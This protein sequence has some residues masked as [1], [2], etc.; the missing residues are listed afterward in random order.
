MVDLLILVEVLDI[1]CGDVPSPLEVE[2]RVRVF[3]QHYS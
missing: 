1:R 2:V 3:N